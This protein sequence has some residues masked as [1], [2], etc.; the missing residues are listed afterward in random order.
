MALTFMIKNV[1]KEFSP[2]LSLSLLFFAVFLPILHAEEVP[3]EKIGRSCLVVEEQTLPG[4]NVKTTIFGTS[5]QPGP[6]KKLAVY[7]VC[8]MDC[9]VAAAVFD[10]KNRNLAHGWKPQWVELK[11]GEEV[12]LPLGTSTWDWTE[13]QE[14]FEV[15]LVFSDAKQKDALERL[16]PLAQAL[17][18]KNGDP[19][20]QDLQ[21]RKLRE[22]LLQSS[23]LDESEA[24]RQG[25]V[26]S[27]WGGTL[28]GDTF[29]W[30]P[31]SQ[32]VALAQNGHALQI[33]R[34]EEKK[35]EL[36]KT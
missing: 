33:Y 15:I 34:Y 10:S 19:H 1:P 13:G 26:P 21:A 25:T 28:R 16:K 27:A 36:P 2:A 11:A 29:H 31:M 30:K 22:I 14:P 6:G 23:G 3:S 12:H 7:A 35:M 24:F 18:N 8:S 4:E 32:K 20:L 17:Q 5:S 9:S